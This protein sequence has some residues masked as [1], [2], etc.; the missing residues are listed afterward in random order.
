MQWNEKCILELTHHN[1]FESTEHRSRFREL[2]DCFWTA[3]FFT[4]GVCKCMYLGAW[5]DEHFLAILQILNDLTAEGAKDAS[6]MAQDGEDLADEMTGFDREAYSLSTA[7]I[8]NSYY[9]VPDFVL[10]DPE[11]AHIIKSTLMAAKYIDD[12]PDPRRE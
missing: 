11:E 6:H 3:P 2:L 8:T 1:L 4:K 5:D 7:F 10:M 12:L 9:R